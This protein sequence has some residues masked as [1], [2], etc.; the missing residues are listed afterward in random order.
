[1]FKDRQGRKLTFREVVQK[2][3]NR[4]KHIFLEFEVFWLHLAGHLPSH[5]LRR[6]FYR[7]AGIKIGRG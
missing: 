4:I 2:V 7:L 6:F 5:H 3:I 1:M